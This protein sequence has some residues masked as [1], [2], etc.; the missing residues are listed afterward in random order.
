MTSDLRGINM[1]IQF[2]EKNPFFV[3]EVSPTDRRATIISKAEEKAFLLEGNSC[4]EAQAC[5]LN[6][7]K[8]LS[9]E[10]DWFCEC[11]EST[12]S[13]IRQCIKNK[14]LIKTNE[15]TGLA[16][17][18]ATLFNFAIS[19]YDDY[20]DIGY[21]IL[22]I[23]EQYGTMTLFELSE[24]LN[25]CHNQAGI[26]EAS[27]DEIER[28]YIKKR[29]QIRKLISTKTQNLS[30]DDYVEFITMI[31]EK[32]IADEDYEDGVVIAD[33][34]YQYE[35]KMQSAIEAA[36]DE[37]STQ[38]GRIKR[39]ANKEGIEANITGLIRRLK[40]WDKLVQPL[41]LKSMASGVTHQIS[42]RV[43]YDVR[44]LCLWLHND[45]EM[46]ETAL[47]LANEMKEIFA[48]IGNLSDVF[49]SD[50]NALSKILREDKDSKEIVA[51]I[52]VIEKII[53]KWK[54]PD[55]STN[56][57][58]LA[59]NAITEDIVNDLIVKVKA[60]NAKIKAISADEEIIIRLR[61][62][63]CITARDGAIYAH[64]ERQQTALALSISR[65]L[66]DEF[67]DLD[68]LREKLSED[69]SALNRQLILINASRSTYTS[70]YQ[71]S[72]SNTAGDSK[73]GW[74]IA[75]IIFAIVIIIAIASG[76]D[77][78]SNSGQSFGNNS[79]Y[80]Q[81]SEVSFSRFLSSGT[82]VYADIV[83]IFPS[84][85]IY[86]EGSSYYTHFVCECETSNGSTV[87]VYM[88]TS[89][90]KKYF[91]S[92]AST[93]VYFS[94]AEEITF[95]YSKRIHG[96]AR[97]ADNVMSDLS[98]DTGVTMLIDFESVGS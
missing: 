80:N 85:G 89:E 50:S 74:I 33:V 59:T 49:I 77:S 97:K 41:Q 58:M 67:G 98:S 16:K 31:A 54:G 96:E 65:V 76:N 75:A 8:R 4:D 30:E 29:E 84:I 81:S 11:D 72:Q 7:S 19:S 27:E 21:A 26:L 48:E 47:L 42:E 5:L 95:S 61:T 1:S 13:N 87:W 39:I 14:T 25:E 55:E 34:V 44:D 2:L 9:A 78:S 93:S 88:S 22:D 66:L 17:L 51:E 86:T 69:V 40:K 12:V 73:K 64:N 91:D 36:T 70:S 43:G 60:L 94:S 62:G 32:C 46:T 71:P 56:S 18:N 82:D 35:L 37:I 68:E 3:L 24:I 10:M 15:L 83:S 45:N 28:E 38:L 92:D 20:F 90:Y 23:D 53:D 79:S 57:Y 52:K 63:L 6:P